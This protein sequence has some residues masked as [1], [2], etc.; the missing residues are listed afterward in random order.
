MR[1]QPGVNHESGVNQGSTGKKNEQ[2][3]TVKT[4]KRIKQSA[5]ILQRGPLPTSVRV[6][7]SDF[8]IFLFFRFLLLGLIRLFR[9]FGCNPQGRSVLRL[10]F[11]TSGLLFT[12]WMGCPV[13]RLLGCSARLLYMIQHY[14]YIYIYIYIH[15]GLVFPYLVVVRGQNP[16]FSFFPL[17]F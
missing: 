3:K 5:G 6:A 16:A 15:A 1:G 9:L 17:V 11:T 8:L 13:A 2:S 7:P 12:T 4:W 14:I 10:L